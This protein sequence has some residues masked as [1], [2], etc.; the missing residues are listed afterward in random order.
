M[1]PVPDNYELFSKWTLAF[2]SARH[3]LLTTRRQEGIEEVKRK[4]I[5]IDRG[6]S[7]SAYLKFC[8]GEPRISVK[9]RLIDG[10]I[11]AYEMPLDFH[12]AVQEEL[13]LIMDF[14][15]D[16]ISVCRPDICIRPR[17]RRQPQPSQAVNSS[18]KPYPTLVVEIGNTESLNNLHELAMKYFSQRTTTQI[19]LAIKS[20]PSVA[21]L[22]LLYLRNNPNPTI[23]VIVKSF[24]IADLSRIYILNTAHVSASVI[25]G[26]GFGGVPCDGGNIPEYQIVISTILLLTMFIIV[27][28]W[29][30]QDAILNK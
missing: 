14:I 7:R 5:I 24:E 6:I 3:K 8:E 9:H 11:E 16:T 15:V 18:E 28:I 30:L 20:F 4:G 23:P 17:N 29:R 12:S 1:S 13:I 21:L 25:T 2:D 27:D 10:K 26:I 19:Y 22:A